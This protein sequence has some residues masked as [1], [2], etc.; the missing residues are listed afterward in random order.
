MPDAT[1]I[2]LQ[3]T[4]SAANLSSPRCFDDKMLERFADAIVALVFKSDCAGYLSFSLCLSKRYHII[5]TQ[6]RTLLQ[7]AGGGLE[8]HVLS[9]AP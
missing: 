7:Q 5:H 6:G 9:P 3:A 4:A 8:I 2:Y 1:L